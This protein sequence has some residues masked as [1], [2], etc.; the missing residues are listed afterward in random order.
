MELCVRVLNIH[1]LHATQL[2]TVRN[3]LTTI[4]IHHMQWF[5]VHFSL[6][7]DTSLNETLP[8]SSNKILN[9]LV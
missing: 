1:T 9:Y 8:I 6:R 3:T 5:K 2:D 4:N 7:D